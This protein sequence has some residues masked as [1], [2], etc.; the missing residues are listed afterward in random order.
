MDRLVHGDTVD[1]NA[2]AQNARTSTEMIDRFYGSRLEGEMAIGKIQSDI[3]KKLEQDPIG[4]NRNGW[5]RNLVDEIDRLTRQSNSPQIAVQGGRI[6]MKDM[7]E[8]S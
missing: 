4:Q 2:I 8:P 5:D 6:V 7:R 3:R 1:V